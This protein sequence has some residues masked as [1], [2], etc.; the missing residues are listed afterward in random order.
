MK[1]HVCSESCF[2]HLCFTDQHRHGTRSLR[3]GFR[4][5]SSPGNLGLGVGGHRCD[6]LSLKQCKAFK[7]EDGGEELNEKKV[8]SEENFGNSKKSEVK[9]ERENEFWNSVK[10]IVLRTLKLGSKFADNDDEHL[11]AVA[12]VEEVLSAVSCFNILLTE[13]FCIYIQFIYNCYSIDEYNF[14]FP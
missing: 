11:R 13:W 12:K 5:S 2:N 14:F 6:G 4:W 9:L 10:S 8:E 1:F 3:Q 7:T